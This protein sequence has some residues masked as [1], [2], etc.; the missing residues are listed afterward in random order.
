MRL[1]RGQ[2]ILLGIMILFVLGAY[3]LLVTI[4][5]TNSPQTP[6]ATPAVLPTV[7]QQSLLVDAP[8][9]TPAAPTETPTPMPTPTRAPSVSTRFD[10]QLLR[11]PDNVELLLDRGNEYL[12]LGAY[13]LA[14]TDFARAQEL[15][16]QRPESSLGQGRALLYLRRWDEAEAAFREALRLNFGMSEAHFWLGRLYYYQGLYQQAAR[17]F[18]WAA[19]YTPDY[20]EAEAWLALASVELYDLPEASGAV[21]RAFQWDAQLPINYVARAWTQVLAGDLEGAQ[22][23]LIYAQGLAPYNFDVLNAQA[24]F[25]AD[26]RP[27]RLAEAERLALQAQRWARWDIEEAQA[28]HTLGRVYLQRGLIDSARTTLLRAVELATVDEQLML[29]QLAEDVQRATP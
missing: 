7:D 14:L 10:L 19:E 1:T 21:E 25:Y 18:D 6:V 8:T 16:P 20:A 24:R 23:D 4:V 12:R 9:P 2:M 15:A 27:E 22:G 26:Y 17:Q 13:T 11:E 29:P 5:I 28:L 3:A